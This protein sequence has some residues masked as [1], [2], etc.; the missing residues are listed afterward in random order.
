[1]ASALQM[2]SRTYS[3]RDAQETEQRESLARAVRS[4]NDDHL[5]VCFHF[6]VNTTPIQRLTV[7]KLNDMT[8]R[9]THGSE[10]SD[11]ATTSVAAQQDVPGASEFGDAINLCARV[12]LKSEMIQQCFHLVLH[13]HEHENRIFAER[14]RG[15][16]QT[17]CRPSKRRRERY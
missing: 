7:S 11:H 16:S 2:E 15:P 6:S 10:V 4:G 13:N 3:V 1:M 9:I 14:R 8:I 5:R 17:L 12:H